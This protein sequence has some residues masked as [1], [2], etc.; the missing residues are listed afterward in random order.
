M[1]ERRNSIANELELRLSC[2]NPT[3]LSI[4][5]NVRAETIRPAHDTI[6]CA[7]WCTRYD[8]FHD[9]FAILSWEA[10]AC[11]HGLRSEALNSI[12]DSCLRSNDAQWLQQWWPPQSFQMQC[13]FDEFS[14]VIGIYW[15]LSA[16]SC[17]RF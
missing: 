15:L 12:Y 2:T 14:R 3:I 7:K 16:L 6:R 13:V 5:V 10:E 17:V 4:P 11:D 8:M 1:L 9:T